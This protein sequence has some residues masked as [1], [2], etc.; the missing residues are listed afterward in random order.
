L[1]EDQSPHA[2]GFER[3]FALLEGTAS[4]FNY[5]PAEVSHY[6][7]DAALVE[8]LPDDFYSSVYYTDRM[9]GYLKEQEGDG[10]PFFAWLAYT[11]PH[12]PLHA[13]PEDIEAQK[14]NYDDGYEVL[15]Q[16]RFAGWKAAGMAA[17]DAELPNLPPDYV[18]WA[19]LS[20]EE[21]ADMSRRMEVY[22][23]M[24][25]RMD[26]EIGRVLSYLEESGQLENTLILFHSDNGPEGGRMVN[27]E[28]DERYDNSLDNIGRPG[29]Y[30]FTGPGWAEASSAPFY[31]R[32]GT[33][34][35]GGIHSPAIVSGPG[36]GVPK[37][38]SDDSLLTASDV[39]PTLLELAGV[40]LELANAPADTLPIT[41]RSFLGVLQ[42]DNSLGKRG[43]EDAVGWELGGQVS[44][45]KGD[46]K[47]LW[48][49]SE[50][51]SPADAKNIVQGAANGTPAS[52]GGPWK[53][54][55][56]V[57]DPT[58]THDLADQYPDVL[59]D[60]I[61]EWNRYVAENG[62]LVQVSSQ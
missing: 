40:E 41:G 39:M 34:A 18:P 28:A 54:F 20:S 59:A 9:I 19:A 26:T 16:H 60:M 48:F 8:K 3:A 62:I 10:Q 56:L 50:R 4:H 49:R 37:G 46:W 7:D 29:S 42:G 17:Q 32:K 11:A 44:I 31:L 33:T 27:R 5:D 58:E 36:L 21:Q 23:A 43:D 38:T 47:L 51:L 55:N 2:R 53:L 14:G 6:R 35:E 61:N 12:W 24:V 30:V 13:L 15:R 22:A 25:E 52:K 45:R 1:E 57:Q